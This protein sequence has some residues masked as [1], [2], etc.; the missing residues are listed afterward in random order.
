VCAG[1][2]CLPQPVAHC[3]DDETL[4]NADGSTKDCGPYK[5]LNDVCKKSCTTVDDCAPSY[6]CGA[7]GLCESVAPQAKQSGGC[8]C[9]LS[10]LR[11]N[12]TNFTWLSIVALVGISAL[13]RRNLG[14]RPSVRGRAS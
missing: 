1:A 10:A 7:T 14:R 6:F 11:G 8:G 12:S 4:T 5:C 2:A 3:S 13:R 9:R